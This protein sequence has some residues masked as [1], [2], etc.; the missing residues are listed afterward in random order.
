MGQKIVKFS[1]LTGKVVESEENLVRIV[2]TQHPDLEGG[3]VEIEALAD[4]LTDVE[5]VALDLVTFELHF[6]GEEP[7]N[8]VMEVEAFNKLAT[9]ADMTEVLKGAKRVTRGSIPSQSGPAAAKEKVNYATLEHA[10]KPKKGRTSDEEKTI[11][12]EHFDEIN[13]RL[14]AEGNRILELDNADH[15]ARYGLEALA[16]E[17]AKASK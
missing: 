8:V 2:V 14:K 16:E 4:E 12:Q 5:E 13:E 9:D 3:P 10:G 11:V 7:E 15:V 1:D 6:P 17:R